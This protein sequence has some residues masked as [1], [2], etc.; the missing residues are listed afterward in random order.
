MTLQ[1]DFVVR[2]D[3]PVTAWAAQRG[4]AETLRFTPA[5]P[6]DAVHPRSVN[7]VVVVVAAASGRP[8]QAVKIGC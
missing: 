1:H 3:E 6:A 8:V 4:A 2:E 7:L 5:R